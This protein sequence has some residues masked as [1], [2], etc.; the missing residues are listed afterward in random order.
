M[1]EGYELDKFGILKQ[2]NPKTEIRD[3]GIERNNYGQQ[4]HYLSYLRLG[5]LKG[6]IKE[7]ESIL[8]VGYG[9]GD[10]LRACQHHFSMCAGYDLIDTYLPEGCIK[11]TDLLADEY[12]VIT[13]YDALEHF[14]DIYFLEKLKCKY[15]VISLPNCKYPKDD[16]WLSQWKHLKPN[17]HLYHMNEKSLTKLLISSG[18]KIECVSYYEDII[19]RDKNL[20]QN[21]LTIIGK[22]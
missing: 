14:E 6:Y 13:F 18:Y 19:R 7:S 21:I 8:D 2:L 5:F 4:S 20:D 11:E 16:V 15:V 9:N 1:L 10:F 3:Y 22:K 17:E 12:D